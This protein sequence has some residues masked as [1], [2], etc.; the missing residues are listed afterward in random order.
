[1]AE[2]KFGYRTE[3]QESLELQRIAPV[4]APAEEADSP[5][6]E[7]ESDPLDED[8]L[9]TPPSSTHSVHSFQLYTPD[10]ERAV[11]R[12]L[13]THLVLFMAF[14]Y[15]L[16]FLDRSNIG[17]AKIAGLTEDLKLHDDQFDWLLTAFYI[18]YIGFEWMIMM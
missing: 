11:L 1:M 10:E 6:Q 16:S 17:N 7:L 3:S 2:T 13:D 12:K 14:C 5:D 4:P 8:A 15:L 18:T 9:D